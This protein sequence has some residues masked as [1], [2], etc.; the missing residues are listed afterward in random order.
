[1]RGRRVVSTPSEPSHRNKPMFT[2][3]FRGL[4]RHRASQPEHGTSKA[5]TGGTC[6]ADSSMNR[7]PDFI[8]PLE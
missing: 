7:F 3:F 4:T 5:G 8:S 2:G 1:M 6:P